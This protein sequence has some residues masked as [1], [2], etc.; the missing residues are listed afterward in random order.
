VVLFWSELCKGYDIG[1]S[2]VVDRYLLEGIGIA[3]RE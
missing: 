3:R 1:M 2:W